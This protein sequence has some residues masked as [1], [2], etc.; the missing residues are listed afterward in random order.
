MTTP[1]R[2]FSSL[3]FAGTSRRLAPALLALGLAAAGCDTGLPSPPGTTDGGANDGGG[4]GDLAMKPDPLFAA[5][6][7]TS[8]TRWTGGN[9]QSPEML[10]GVA[11]IDC[12]TRMR[13]P[14]M[15]IG[16]TVYPTGHEPDDCNGASNEVN[17]GDAVVE[18]KGADGKVL[19]LAV[20]GTSGNFHLVT[21]GNSLVKPYTAKVILNGKERVM[22]TP[23][24]NGD[25][26][27]CHTAAG[28]Q[29]APGRIVIP[30][31]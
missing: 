4:G 16:G 10:P 3:L 28:A 27:V 5:P 2:S 9:R 15:F 21:R 17:L 23:Q 24:M 14:S 1:V 20:S 30:V 6:T 25:C 7:C 22:A 19:M 13:G 12:H 31:Q 8:G 26:N 29:G 18:I 11:C